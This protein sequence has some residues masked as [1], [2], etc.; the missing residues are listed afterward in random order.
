MRSLRDTTAGKRSG[1]KPFLVISANAAQ[2]ALVPA[3]RAGATRPLDERATEL[4]SAA[5]EANPVAMRR[6]SRR[7]GDPCA[8]GVCWPPWGLSK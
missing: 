7:A 4:E 6:L 1:S 3:L 2:I 5:A 8:A